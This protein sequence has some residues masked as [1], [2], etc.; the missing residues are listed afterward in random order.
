MALNPAWITGGLGLLGSLFGGSSARAAQESANRTNIKLQ[1]DQLEW[2]EK[3]ANTEWQRGTQD[4]LA[5]GMN[6]MLAFSQGGA[7]SP[8][9]SAAQVI[10]EDG[11]ARAV[12]SAATSLGQTALMAANIDNI[13]A[14]TRVAEER[15]R[16]EEVT[17]NRMISETIGGGDLPPSIM[18]TRWGKERDEAKRAK[19]EREA[20][21]METDILRAIQSSRIASAKSQANILEK[22][23]DF[24]EARKILEQL[25]I[26][27]ARAMANWF[28][29]VGAASP[30]AKATMSIASW[31]K[32]II[33]K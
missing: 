17:A 22:Q 7:S 12:T 29:M 27:E 10:P 5:A 21:E 28:E 30:A 3:M 2:Q 19:A 23:V 15:A 1:K 24:E 32:Y 6:P 13:K 33:G 20:A 8:N 18:E 9:V 14:N 11:M 26:P 4:M 31:V 25:K 16:Q